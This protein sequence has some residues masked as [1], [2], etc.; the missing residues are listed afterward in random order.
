MNADIL[1]KTLS[2]LENVTPLKTDCGLLCGASCCRDNG[3][4]G[5]AV[6]LLPGEEDGD[7]SWAEVS[8]TATPVTGTPMKQIYCNAF[9]ERT[10]RPFLCR[11][12]PL[13]PYY[14]KTKSIWS[15][16]MDR[17]AAALCPLFM[18]GIRGLDPVFTGTCREA[19]R[20]IAS[21]PEGEQL[22][23]ILE[24]EEDAYRFEL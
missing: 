24:A 4:A 21:D 18:C 14:S 10:K 8:D 17:R 9:C 2:L 5:S 16:R 19:V 13:S 1:N 20:L 11:I 7:F 23:R 3:E 12:F 15:V 6:W 22:L